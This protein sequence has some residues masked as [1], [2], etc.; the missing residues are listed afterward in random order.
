M[1]NSK[2]LFAI[3]PRKKLDPRFS[4]FVCIRFTSFYHQAKAND[5]TETFNHELFKRLGSELGVLG[6]TV[7][8]EF[9]GAGLDATAVAITLEEICAADPGYDFVLRVRLFVS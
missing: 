7:S 6:I 3:L 9:G 1:Y 5:A 4:C 8:E 2:K